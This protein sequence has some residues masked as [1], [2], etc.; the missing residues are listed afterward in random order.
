MPEAGAIAA[1]V[2]VRAGRVLLARRRVAEGG[3]SWQFPA[4]KV[5]PGE[6]VQEAAVREAREEA[7]VISAASYV[8]GERV[9]PVTG[10]RVFY[11]A[12]DLISGTARVAAGDEIV[13]VAWC[14]IAEVRSYVPS[15]F[16]APVQAYLDAVLR[17]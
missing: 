15:G 13:E 17:S 6:T 11:V 16:F 1:A 8:L 3:L 14:D 5:E 9:H 12:C 7:A 4:G 10:R 2:I